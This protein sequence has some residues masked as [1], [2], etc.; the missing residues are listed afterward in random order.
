MKAGDIVE[1]KKKDYLAIK[2]N[3]KS[4]YICENRN[5]LNLWEN[6]A[7]GV[8]WKELCDREGAIKVKPE[9]LTLKEE[10]AVKVTPKQSKKK[11]V[12]SNAGEQYLKD[13]MNRLEK[14]KKGKKTKTPYFVAETGNE[15]IA[16]MIG[17]VEKQMILFHNLSLD[18]YHFFDIE[19]GS[20]TT[21]DKEK[22][23][24][25]KEIIWP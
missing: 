22:H 4:A 5:F 3:E 16:I 10:G 17:N 9:Q 2:V 6:R 14:Q 24:S 7:K 11:R 23:K 15:K 18:T 19:N 12:L 25:G 21:F 1:Y 20:Y 13:S 8:K